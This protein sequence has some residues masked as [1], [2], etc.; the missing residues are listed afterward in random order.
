[1]TPG[2]G[3]RVRLAALAAEHGAMEV[4]VGL[5]TGLSGRP[6]AAAAEARAFAEALADSI[7]I[8]HFA[9]GNDTLG[10]EVGAILMEKARAGVEVRVLV[11]PAG[12]AGRRAVHH[13]AR[14]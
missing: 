8:A 1:M 14:P 11:D 13:R 10:R 6:G 2:R 7:H 4:I 3:D 5:P 12:A 9:I